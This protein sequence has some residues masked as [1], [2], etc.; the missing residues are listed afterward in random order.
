MISMYT[1][2]CPK[3]QNRCWY[4]IGSPPPA[5]SKNAVLKLRSVSIIVI[6]PA[7]TGRDSSSSTAVTT[8]AHP[9]S[10]S[11]CSLI[12]GLRIFSIVVMKLIAPSRLLIPDR[13]RANIARSTLG[14]LWLCIPDRGGYSVHPVP[15]P[16]SITLANRN[17]SRLGGS[18]QNDM[19]F[20]RGNAISGPPTSSGSRKLPNPPIM[21]GITMKNIITIA[22]AV[23]IL[24]YSWLSAMN[25]T[26]GPDSSSLIST[27]NAVPIRPLN[28]ANIKYRVPISLALLDRNQRSHQRDMLVVRALSVMCV[29]IYVECLH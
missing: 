12:P 29:H 3:N 18:S 28:R 14:P 7:S 1:S 13:C 17:S 25:C 19:L 23:M 2:G 6:P 15:A 20:R 22:W 4:R 27:E 11:L 26:P 5:T 8:T 24:L 16:F 10:A 9:N 21:A